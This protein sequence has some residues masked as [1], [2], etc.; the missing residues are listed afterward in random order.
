MG[1]TSVAIIISIS[2]AAVAA[3]QRTQAPPPPPTTG[4]AEI[5]GTVMTDEANPRPVR[6]AV[7]SLNMASAPIGGRATTT[8]DAGRFVFRRLPA[9]NYG[10]PRA[11]KA[12]YVSATY[13]EKR[14]GGIGSPITLVDGQRLTIALKMLRGAVITGTIFDQGR[15]ASG[16]AVQATAIRVVNGTRSV[17]DTYY[18]AGGGYGTSDDRGVYRMYGMPPGDYM[19]SVSARSAST[20][21]PTRPVTEAEMQWAQQQLQGSSAVG[22]ASPTGASSPPPPAQAVAAAP[23]YYPGTTVAAQA[24]LVTVAA[25]QERGGVD[26]ALQTVPTAKVAGTILGLDGQ[27]AATATVTMVPRVDTSS[28]QVDAML[29]RESMIMG[30]PPVTEGK[31]VVQ[32]VKPGDYTIA[33]RGASRSDAPAGGGRGGPAPVMNLWAS[34]DISVNGVDQTDLVLRLVPGVDIAGRITFEG[35]TEKPTDFSTIQ[36]RLRAAPTAGV[37]VSVGAASTP[38]AA[39]GTFTLKG[40]TPGRYLVTSFVP[41]GGVTPVWTMKSARVGDVDAGDVPFEIG[42]GRDPSDIAVTFTDKMGEL[43]GRLLDGTNKPT[44]ALSIILFPTDKTMWSQTSRRIRSPIR[45]ANDGVFKFTNVLAGEYFLAALSDFDMA[46]VYKPEFL[47]QVAA[48]A[49]KITIGD[50]EKKAQDLKIAGGLH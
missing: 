22:A 30:R 13:G 40:V 36:V 9:G 32:A 10:A 5:S 26:F 11:T 2:V 17:T 27:P 15:P 25:G 48:V 41:G 29:M 37:T 39:D 50:G 44:S 23:V 49:M 8:D 1:M 31:F 45:P 43:S 47:E 12:G 16:V 35:E 46:D 20:A 34:A 38:V 7:I 19:V 14:V 4:T 28:A 24:T 42:A 21:A 6:R 18:Y 3:Q 33:V